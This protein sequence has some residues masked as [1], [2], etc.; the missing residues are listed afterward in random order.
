MEITLNGN[1]YEL[2][3]DVSN[4]QQLLEHLE[5]SKRIV[6]V[7]VN[8]EIVQKDDYDRPIRDRDEVEMIH[9]VG[10]G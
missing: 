10:G 6:I 7:E 2:P 1:S 3:E 5:L 8:K 9:F 4:V